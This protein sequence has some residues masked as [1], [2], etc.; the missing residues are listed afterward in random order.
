MKFAILLV[1]FAVCG[2]FADQQSDP[3]NDWEN[4]AQQG[5]K[6]GQYAAED[7]IRLAQEVLGGIFGHHGQYGHQNDGKKDGSNSKAGKNA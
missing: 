4:V 5:I 3:N 7:G 6:A 1:V 2:T